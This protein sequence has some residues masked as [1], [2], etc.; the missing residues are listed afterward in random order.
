LI[1]FAEIPPPSPHTLEFSFWAERFKTTPHTPF[2]SHFVQNFPLEMR[3]LIELP[4]KVHARGPSKP[5]SLLPSSEDFLFRELLLSSRFFFPPFASSFPLESSFF[6]LLTLH[7]SSCEFTDV[8]PLQIS[9]RSSIAGLLAPADMILPFFIS[10]TIPFPPEIF[11]SPGDSFL[12]AKPSHPI[13]PPARRPTFLFP[14]NSEDQQM[15]SP[16]E[17]NSCHFMAFFFPSCILLYVAV[18]SVPY[19]PFQLFH[20]GDALHLSCSLPL[21]LFPFFFH[22]YYNSR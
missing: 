2:L 9:T 22:Y 5:I 14:I 20:S 18:S 19:F 8:V 15:F 3:V 7:A 17:S 4:R 16:S 13:T 11:N 12:E 6:S 21:G 1:L 10:T